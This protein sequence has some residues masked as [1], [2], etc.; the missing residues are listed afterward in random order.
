[1]GVKAEKNFGDNFFWILVGIP[2]T[3]QSN[4][5]KYHI[6]YYVIPSPDMSKIVNKQHG[7]FQE[8]QLKKKGEKASH[9]MR[10]LCIPPKET[11]WSDSI[12]KY[13]NK[14]DF[15]ERKLVDGDVTI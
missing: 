15:I 12:K 2:T 8:Q 10:T 6:D 4:D 7:K 13:L 3:D 9:N 14:W 11:Y 1:V 5:T